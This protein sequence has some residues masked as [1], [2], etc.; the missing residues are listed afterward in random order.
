MFRYPV[1]LM[2]FH[3]SGVIRLGVVGT[4]LFLGKCRPG[5]GRIAT[6]CFRGE[7]IIQLWWTAVIILTFSDIFSGVCLFYLV[8]SCDK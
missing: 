3:T 6:R 7:D 1:K 4:W 2:P 8:I 5:V